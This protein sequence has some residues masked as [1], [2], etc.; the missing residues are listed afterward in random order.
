MNVSSLA[1]LA[2]AV[3]ALGVSIAACSTTNNNAVEH[4]SALGESCLTTADCSSGVCVANTCVAAASA[5]GGM[6]TSSGGSDSGGTSSGMASSSGGSSSGAVVPEAAPPHLGVRGD[7]CSSTSDCGPS[8]D[9][10]YTGAGVGICD[11]ATYNLGA[12]ATGKTCTGE[13]NTAAD[14]CD[15]PVDVVIGGTEY[16][17][18]N[19]IKNQVIGA[20]NCPTAP[21]ATALG[22]GCFYYNTYCG[23]CGSAWACTASQCIYNATC[24]ASGPGIGGC[25]DETRTGRFL[26]STCS[27]TGVCGG[28][29]AGTCMASSDC[30]G[31]AYVAFPGEVSGTCRAPGATGTNDCV[32]Q[33]GSCYLGCS[34]DLD[35]ATGY[36]CDTTTSLC[37]VAGSCQTDA[38]C[39]VSQ[40]NILSKCVSG[41]CTR[42]CQTDHDCS[43]FS[44][45]VGTFSGSVC[46]SGT[47]QVLGCTMDSDCNITSASN[48]TG[49]H[50]FCTGPATAAAAPE[51]SA[52]TN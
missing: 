51:V 15:L 22:V 24:T 2:A 29:G 45:V 41:S 30:A 10:I 48:P 35:C 23:T 40:G 32:C 39:A 13:C 43:R 16:H 46:N 19:D 28:T 36:T 52:I 12:A 1:T 14:C 34:K 31:R 27:T 9:C 4:S 18:C 6:G 3:A 38:Q 37:K 50:L 26:S 49:V 33:A 11:L 8:L 47:C 25:P 44:G 17:H 21:D 42:P 20:A 5:E 7:V